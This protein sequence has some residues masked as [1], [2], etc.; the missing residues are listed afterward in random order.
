MRA[1]GQERDG[2]EGTAAADGRIEGRLAPGYAAAGQGQLAAGAN[3][4]CAST[5][6]GGEGW[7][8]RG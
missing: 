7:R 3:Q 6:F 2:R 8:H 4:G 5:A 1:A